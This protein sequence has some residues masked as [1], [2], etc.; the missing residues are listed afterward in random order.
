LLPSRSFCI[1]DRARVTKNELLAEGRRE[2]LAEYRW[3]AGQVG[4]ERRRDKEL[5]RRRLAMEAIQALVDAIRKVDQDDADTARLTA[6]VAKAMMSAGGAQREAW[7]K[8]R[9]SLS[10]QRER[11]YVESA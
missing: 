5:M 6:M 2:G 1:T 3:R 7:L 8:S 11:R 10:T 4:R 9:P